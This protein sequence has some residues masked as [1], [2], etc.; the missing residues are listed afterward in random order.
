MP[1]PRPSA[2]GPR[3]AETEVDPSTGGIREVVGEDPAQPR[4]GRRACVTSTV[5]LQAATWARRVQA[6]T[7]QGGRRG[8]ANNAGGVRGGAPG[9]L[10][11]PSGSATPASSASQRETTSISSVSPPFRGGR[12]REREGGR[13]PVLQ[14]YHNTPPRR[15]LLRRAPDLS[16]PRSTKYL[17][18]GVLATSHPVLFVRPA[19][20]KARQKRA[21]T[22]QRPSARHRSG[23]ARSLEATSRAVAQ[24]TGPGWSGCP[25]EWPVNGAWLSWLVHVAGS[26]VTPPVRSGGG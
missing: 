20:A 2:A 5:R 24:A 17:S 8:R 25:P 4:G 10:D 16:V 11:A 7:S 19:V 13:A 22:G 6:P 3:E 12:P 18:E 23:S 14:V 21:I 1:R 9:V 26:R 15:C